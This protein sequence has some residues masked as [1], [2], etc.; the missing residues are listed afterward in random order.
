MAV[1]GI[2]ACSS[3]RKRRMSTMESICST[4]TGHSCMQAPQVTQSHN[5]SSAY[6]VADHR[7]GFL[8]VVARRYAVAELQ[9]VLFHV[10]YDMH[11]RQ[12]LAR[13]V[14]GA[15]VGAASAD[16]A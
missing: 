14:G 10:L 1:S 9:D 16:G 4:P 13:D 15:V 11:G 6:P 2:E 8:L 3:T 12:Y 5:A 7:L